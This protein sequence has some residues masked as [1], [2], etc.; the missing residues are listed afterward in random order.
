M[1][2]HQ[3]IEKIVF[4]FGLIIIL[5]IFGYLIFQATWKESGPPQLSLTSFPDSKMANNAFEVHVKNTGKQTA[6]NASIKVSLFQNGKSVES[7]TLSFDYIPTH[8]EVRGWAVFTSKHTPS[9]SLAVS[10]LGFIQE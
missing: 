5:A 4:G 10:S 9:D 2:K 7:S 3:P 1:Q 6:V 8:S